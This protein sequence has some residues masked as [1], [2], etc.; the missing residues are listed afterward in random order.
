M[1]LVGEDLQ[2]IKEVGS[3]TVLEAAMVS[4]KEKVN[5]TVEIMCEISETV[6]VPFK[7]QKYVQLSLFWK[8]DRHMKT[9]TLRKVKSKGMK[10]GIVERYCSVKEACINIK[11]KKE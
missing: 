4:E 6:N 9:I 1:L 8:W 3:R 10:R 5:Q 2:A 11:R 7:K